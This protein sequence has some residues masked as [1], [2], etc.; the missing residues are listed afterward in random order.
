MES[1]IVY[2]KITTNLPIAIDDKLIDRKY[3]YGN[4]IFD[5]VEGAFGE[6]LL[7]ASNATRVRAVLRQAKRQLNASNEA[8]KMGNI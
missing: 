1:T 2:I 4:S 8:Y 7:E 6:T 3:G 5:E